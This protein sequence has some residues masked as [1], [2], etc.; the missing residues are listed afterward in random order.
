MKQV[1]EILVTDE[2][3]EQ[4]LFDDDFIIVLAEFEYEINY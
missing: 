4:I 2:T 1:F 3:F